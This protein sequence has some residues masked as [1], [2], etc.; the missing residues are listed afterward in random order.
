LSFQ[1]KI[2]PKHIT[3]PDATYTVE[4]PLDDTD[5]LFSELSKVVDTHFPNADATMTER[6]D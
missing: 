6:F 5:L 2:G 3:D 4:M 1:H